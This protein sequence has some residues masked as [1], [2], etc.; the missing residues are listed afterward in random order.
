MR[1]LPDGSVMVITIPISFY[2]DGASAQY[3][4]IAKLTA[5]GALDGGYGK[6]GAVDHAFG[7]TFGGESARILDDG[8]VE[9]VQSTSSR[10]IRKSRLRPDGSLDTTLGVAGVLSLESSVAPEAYNAPLPLLMFEDGSFLA[11]AFQS[12]SPQDFAVRVSRYGP[13][14]TLDRSFGI[15]GVATFP[16]LAAS[17]FDRT[18]DGGY[19]FVGT[20]SNGGVGS[21][22]FTLF[23][24]TARGAPDPAFGVNGLANISL[25]VSADT[26]SVSPYAYRVTPEGYVA[27]L[28]IAMVPHEALVRA[29][30][31]KVQVVGDIVEFHNTSLDHYFVTYDG[32]EARGIDAGM[33]GPGWSR[34]GASFRPGG[35]TPVCRFYGTPGVGP[36]SHF[37][38]AGA[39]ECEAVKH[40]LGWTY[41]G[42]GFYTTPPSDGWCAASLVPVHRL[43]NNRAAQ[44]DSNHRFVT[45]TTLIPAMEA[46]G[47]VHEGVAFCGKP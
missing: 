30:V 27:T 4:T 29:Y 11:Y 3:M 32:D 40:A 2:W 12:A 13:D 1:A 24:T 36:N 6:A 21:N 15:D 17:P 42:L 38:T 8:S 43:Y 25:P 37:F 39:D 18:P 35:T 44:N 41:E 33:A 16:S 9:L 19:L 45:D 20:G 47:W 28:A 31:A 22:G 7:Y 23:K 5:S 26:A 34:T 10:T 46:K 14:F